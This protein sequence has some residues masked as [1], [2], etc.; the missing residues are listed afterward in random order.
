MPIGY[1]VAWNYTQGSLYGLAVSG[2]DG[3]G[4]FEASFQT[5]LS[6]LSGGDFGPE[7]GLLDTGMSLLG[8]LVLYIWHRKRQLRVT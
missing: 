7:A 6:W 1:H 3:N 8:F 4:V 2:N 5:H